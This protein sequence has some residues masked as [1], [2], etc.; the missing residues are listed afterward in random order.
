MGAPEGWGEGLL[1]LHLAVLGQAALVWAAPAE[2]ARSPPH[3]SRAWRVALEGRWR[4]A[5]LA[6]AMS[7]GRFRLAAELC[8]SGERCRSGVMCRFAHTAA[9]RAEVEAAA[10]AFATAVAWPPPPTA[11]APTTPPHSPPPSP[12]A[13]PSPPPAA[14]AAFPRAPPA[15]ADLDLA[16]HLVGEQE[17]TIEALAALLAAHGLGAAELRAAV[18]REGGSIDVLPEPPEPP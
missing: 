7:W 13:P 18:Q 9:E 16:L 3:L 1:V 15:A 6:L 12:R 10:A 4:P 11:P 5:A 8:R 17:R 2:P 14:E